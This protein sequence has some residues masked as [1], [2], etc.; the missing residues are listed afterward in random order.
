MSSEFV[1]L[2]FDVLLSIA[3][4]LPY[5][6][7]L[8]LGQ[9]CSEL[10]QFTQTRPI[11]RW[12]AQLILDGCVGLG[13]NGF[14]GGALNCLSDAELRHS[15]DMARKRMQWAVRE[16]AP[17][18]R[19]SSSHFL[20]DS[21]SRW[22]NRIDVDDSLLDWVSP[23]SSEY[24]LCALKD[25]QVLVLDVHRNRRP[26][27]QWVP[28]PSLTPGVIDKWELWKCRVEFAH[29]KVWFVMARWLEEYVSTRIPAPPFLTSLP[30]HPD[31]TKKI[32]LNS[33]SS[34]STFLK[35]E[36]PALPSLPLMH[37]LR[38]RAPS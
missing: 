38:S 30:A 34:P 20:N 10:R 37:V 15:V 27:A 36:T 35:K 22:Y 17:A 23:I 9:T 12:T 29:R 33:H 3:I 2:P 32:S 6:D 14:G 13:V 31:K 18:T 21:P 28:P 11:L 19:Q 7:V 5:S 25:G 1:A 4:L 8:A 26:L 24:L 16:P